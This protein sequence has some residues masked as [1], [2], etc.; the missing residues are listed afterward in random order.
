MAWSARDVHRV[1]SGSRWLRPSAN[2]DGGSRMTGASI[3]TRTLRAG[4]VFFAMRGES[5]DG[6]DFLPQAASRGALM[7]VIED[8]AGAVPETPQGF[9]VLVVESCR[10][11]MGA[12]ARAHRERFRGRVVAVT[13]SN[14]KTTTVRL[15]DA[16]LRAS[17]RGRGPQKSFNNALGVP[18]TLLG[19]GLEDDYLLCE[20]GTSAPG[21]IASLGDI[22]RPHVAV[23]T[24]AARA[25]V[26]GLGGLD[27]VAKEKASLA[28]CVVDGGIVISNADVAAL[29]DAVQA[30]PV[31]LMRFGFSSGADLRIDGVRPE[32]RAE[33]RGGVGGVVFEVSGRWDGVA[34]DGIRGF[35]PM[36]G[37]HNAMNAGAALGVAI[38]LGVEPA[39]A[40]KGMASA[41]AP[42]MRLQARRIG[43]V[44]IINDAYNANPDSMLA[45]IETLASMRG[46]GRLVAVLGDMLELGADSLGPHLEVAE[47]LAE[48][49]ID[50][51]ILGG[52]S[53]LAVAE[54]L[55]E[56]GIP[57]VW[58]ESF[59]GRGAAEAAG[60]VREG[61]TVLLKGSRRMG[62]ERVEREI[63]T[64]MTDDESANKLAGAR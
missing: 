57:S 54:R 11:A 42:P 43:R 64:R 60:L 58:V 51:S 20:V 35:V 37:L 17:L 28:G 47:A 4:E 61:D 45:A 39:I 19:A 24:T 41:E 33:Q 59:D 22:I 10:D 30:H 48:S 25:H 2:A 32:L 38:A 23:I 31:R 49:S 16:A 55:R 62:V 27:G 3:D 50:L 63:V 8:E 34:L 26:A 14:G 44:T 18:L 46:A 7:A 9:G 40:L 13:G 36:L 21:E 12:L 56:R 53:M 5:V 15:I 29:D 1:L 6:R 52:G